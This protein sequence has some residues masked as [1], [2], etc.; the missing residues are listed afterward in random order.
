MDPL[1]RWRERTK[2]EDPSSRD[3][4]KI[5]HE[6]P[7]SI[8]CDQSQKIELAKE[9]RKRKVKRSSM[10]E[11][12]GHPSLVNGQDP[13]GVETSIHQFKNP[14]VTHDHQ[15]R[16]G[17]CLSKAFQ[18]R[19]AEDEITQRALVDHQ[20]RFNP[21][22]F[23]KRKRGLTHSRLIKRFFPNAFEHLRCPV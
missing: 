13:L 21:M 23:P 11:E 5:L 19:Q 12:R 6:R 2:V 17:K 22:A 20:Y 16:P 3:T 10:D 7:I 14:W 15:L 1:I 9:P 4:S 8:L 18:G